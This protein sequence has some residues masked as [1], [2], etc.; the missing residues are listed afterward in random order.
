M[1]S[2]GQPAMPTDPLDDAVSGHAEKTL[3]AMA[4][5]FDAVRQ[6]SPDSP[7]VGAIQDLMTATSEVKRHIVQIGPD[8]EEGTEDDATGAVDTPAEGPAP[9]DAEMPMGDAGMEGAMP[10]DAPMDPGPMGGGPMNE[11]G[12]GMNQAL[13]D[14][15]KRKQPY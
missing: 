7:L 8:L 6:K 9:P 13:A 3:Q 4:L 11:A 10:P 5:L 12:R 2:M 1:A 15:A 14:A